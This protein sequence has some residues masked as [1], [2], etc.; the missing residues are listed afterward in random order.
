MTTIQILPD[1]RLI[2]DAKLTLCS[3]RVLS[4]SGTLST[5]LCSVP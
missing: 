5:Q 3:R 4:I 2:L 1:S